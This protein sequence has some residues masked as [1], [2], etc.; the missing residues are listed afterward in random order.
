M[1]DGRAISLRSAASS[2]RDHRH[3]DIFESELADHAV[4][5]E[6]FRRY[7]D[8]DSRPLTPAPTSECHSPYFY[9]LY[10]CYRNLFENYAILICS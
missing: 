8:T 1:S 6:F 10:Y 2:R 5:E 7:T 3:D 9:Y 4:P